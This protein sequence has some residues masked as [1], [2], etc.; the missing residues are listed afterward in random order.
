[1]F[2]AVDGGVESIQLERSAGGLQ[3][4]G[5]HFYC[6]RFAGSV[7]SEKRKDLAALDL[8]GDVVYCGNI[9]ETLHEFFYSDHL[10]PFMRG[11]YSAKK[12]G[13]SQMQKARELYTCTLKRG[14]SLLTPLSEWCDS[15]AFRSGGLH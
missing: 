6:S 1:H 5:E 14:A 2:V 8:E 12:V 15:F 10:T 3:Q 11:I 13:T 4:G 9:T 7:W